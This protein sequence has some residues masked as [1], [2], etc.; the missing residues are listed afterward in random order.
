MRSF[1]ASSLTFFTPFPYKMCVGYIWS[2]S[3]L[4][5]SDYLIHE[6]DFFPPSVPLSSFW[7]TCTPKCLIFNQF[8]YTF[9]VY[10]DRNWQRC[11]DLSSITRTGQNITRIKWWKGAGL[12]NGHLTLEWPESLCKL[13]LAYVLYFGLYSIIKWWAPAQTYIK[14]LNIYFWYFPYQPLPS[15]MVV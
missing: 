13:W 5:L 15:S 8:W 4:K 9:S 2:I 3:F 14:V 7:R 10:L 6:G 11:I 12:N 1:D